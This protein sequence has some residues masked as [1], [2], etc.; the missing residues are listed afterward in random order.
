MYLPEFIGEKLTE[1]EYALL[2]AKLISARC[3]HRAVR[4]MLDTYMD[5]MDADWPIG[6][7]WSVVTGKSG[8]VNDYNMA[9]AYGDSVFNAGTASILHRECGDELYELVSY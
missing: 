3:Q 2:V 7:R 1:A 8:T 6:E 4:D 9:Q 5:D